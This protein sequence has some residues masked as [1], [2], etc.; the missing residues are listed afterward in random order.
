[1]VIHHAATFSRADIS[2]TDPRIC[3]SQVCRRGLNEVIS[4]G[5]KPRPREKIRTRFL[6]T[7][8]NG[9][10]EICPKTPV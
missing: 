10:S 2:E 6:H 3:E 8:V 4:T 1:M 7:F 9:S 5:D